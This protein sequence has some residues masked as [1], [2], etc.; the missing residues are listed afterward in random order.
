MCSNK[1]GVNFFKKDIARSLRIK[2]LKFVLYEEIVTQ[3]LFSQ[4]VTQ[5]VMHYSKKTPTSLLVK[6]QIFLVQSLTEKDEVWFRYAI[7]LK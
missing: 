2:K 4:Q 7:S 3:N 5:S 1:D 6:V